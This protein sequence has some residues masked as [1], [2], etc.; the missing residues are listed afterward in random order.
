MERP[1]ARSDAL[2]RSV[3]HAKGITQP[4]SFV[5]ALT[6]PPMPRLPPK[7]PG[8]ART[9]I[10]CNVKRDYP[11]AP[12]R[13]ARPVAAQRSHNNLDCIQGDEPTRSPDD[14]SGRLLGE[15]IE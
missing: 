3:P 5:A 4:P 10:L 12:T 7:F 15:A 9:G 1:R 11:G 8:C 2:R 6:W 13:T 14:S